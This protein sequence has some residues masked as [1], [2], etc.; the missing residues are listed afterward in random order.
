MKHFYHH[1]E[2]SNKVFVLLHGTGGRETDLL[3]V[4]GN[5]DAT[6]SVLGIRGDVVEDGHFRYFKRQKDGSM[7]EESLLSNTDR[8]LRFINDASSRYQMDGRELHLIGY[9]NGANM[10]V[11]L[12]LHQPCL[13]KSAIL[14]HPSNPLSSFNGAL[15]KDIEVFL[16][17]GA[18][19]QMVLPGE[20]FQLKKHL[21]ELH[22]NVKVHLTDK[23]HELV[24]EEITEAAKW[25]KGQIHNEGG[26]R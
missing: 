16:T 3:H 1:N 17:S 24:E 12:L 6:L 11:S 7:D 25:W 20:V 18:R 13:F 4:A 19:D 9:S 10:A 26:S 22:A 8:L 23:G 2:E 21:L 14:L 15:L 5:V